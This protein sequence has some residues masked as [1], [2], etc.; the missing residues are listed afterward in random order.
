MKQEEKANMTTVLVVDD[1]PDLVAIC[2]L[3]L[4]DEGYTVA[5]AHNGMEAFEAIESAPAD[6][7]LMD[8]MMPIMDGITV[9]KMVK[10]DPRTKGLPVII[11]SASE[12][13]CAQ[14][15]TASADAVIA[16]PFDIDYLVSTV[17]QFAPI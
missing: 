16:K 3:V 1:D 5:I 13:L 8:V 7:V 10:R 12:T 14:A 15:R 17:N 4:E 2:S 9:C 11:M 6:V